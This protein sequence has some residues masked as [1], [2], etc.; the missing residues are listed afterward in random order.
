[1]KYRFTWRFGRGRTRT[2][3]FSRVS[4][5]TLQPCEQPVQIDAVLSS[6]QARA[7]WRKSFESSEPTGQRST[8][9]PAQ[10]WSRRAFGW[11]PMYAR[12]PRSET[13]ITGSPARSTSP[14]AGIAHTSASIPALGDVDHGL[15]RQVLHE[16]DAARAQDAAIR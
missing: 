6:S 2:T 11:M 8:T 9:F 7:L 3:T 4:S 15:P 1:M 16:A 10:G 13:L 12:S 14:S 5:V